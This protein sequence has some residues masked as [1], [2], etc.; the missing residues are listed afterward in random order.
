MAFDQQKYKDDYNLEHYDRLTVR[1]LKGQ[2]ED[3]K[4]LATKKGMSVN[5]YISYLI[6]CA[7]TS[8]K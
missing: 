5:G 2:K 4:D 8:R 1:L 7:Q 3:L 6:E